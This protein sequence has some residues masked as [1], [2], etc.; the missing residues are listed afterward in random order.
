MSVI[1]IGKALAIRIH[2]G[3]VRKPLVKRLNRESRDDLKAETTS[4]E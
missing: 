4:K 2:R 3:R 1:S